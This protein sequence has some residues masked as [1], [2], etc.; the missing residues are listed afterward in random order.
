MHTGAFIM[1]EPWLDAA[2]EVLHFLACRACAGLSTKRNK[3]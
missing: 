3:R 2:R 1:P